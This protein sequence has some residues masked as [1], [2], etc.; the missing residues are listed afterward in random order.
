KQMEEKF[1]QCRFSRPVVTIQQCE[2]V[3]VTLLLASEIKV[4]GKVTEE[5]RCFD[6][7]DEKIYLWGWL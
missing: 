7:P 4:V 3:C 1:K 6:S 2:S 5:V